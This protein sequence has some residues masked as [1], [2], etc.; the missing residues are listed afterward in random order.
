MSWQKRRIFTH[1]ASLEL[2]KMYKVSEAELNFLIFW[3]L[4]VQA[5]LSMCVKA[6]RHEDLPTSYLYC[7]S[8]PYPACRRVGVHLGCVIHLITSCFLWRGALVCEPSQRCDA[9][10]SLSGC[11]AKPDCHSVAKLT[12][13]DCQAESCVLWVQGLHFQMS[14]PI[15]Y[16][17]ADPSREMHPLASSEKLSLIHL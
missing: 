13:P 1:I 6:E 9:H 4:V 7:A 2:I 17:S 8:G 12:K 10:V 14:A 16:C 3:G 15:H 5:W 11:P